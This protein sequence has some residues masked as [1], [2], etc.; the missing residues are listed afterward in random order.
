[1]LFN[2]NDKPIYPKQGNLERH[3]RNNHG[4][5]FHH[6]AMSIALHLGDV[7]TARLLAYDTTHLIDAQVMRNGTLPLELA[8]P[9]KIH[10]TCYAMSAFMRCVRCLTEI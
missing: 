1:M 10:Y 7:Y 3:H 2:G 6:T 4:I 9:R 5:W 8:R